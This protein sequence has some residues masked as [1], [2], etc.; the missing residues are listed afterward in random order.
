M[1][2]LVTGANGFIGHYLIEVLLAKGYDVIATG[3]GECRLPFSGQS[4]FTY[5]M[6]DF[7][8]INS[9]NRIFEAHKPAVVVHAGAN[10]KPDEC[11]VDKEAAFRINVTGT[12]N[13]LHASAGQKAFFIFLSTDFIFDGKRGMY[14]E[15][16][17]PGPVNYYGETKLMGEELVQKYV[18]PFSII[19][20]IL[21]YG[22]P[23]TGRGNILTV[24][25]DKLERGEV[26]NVFDDQVRT[27]TY[28]E[29]LTSAITSVIEKKATGIYHIG[30]ADVLTPYEMACMTADYHRLDKSLLEKVTKENFS[31]P[32]LRPLVT[33]LNIDK[34]R[35]QLEY[36]PIS[37]QEGLKKTFHDQK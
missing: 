2:I 20:T 5:A 3:K 30:G 23:L 14:S 24:V 6:L 25:K 11:E 7:T 1:K 16:D 31:Q 12:E 21:V 27:P 28:V 32:A 15:E 22:K 18:F 29:D 33:G 37:F 35:K 4:G 17:Q 9:V 13:M 36:N 8:D 10:G 34:A 19:R 26:Y